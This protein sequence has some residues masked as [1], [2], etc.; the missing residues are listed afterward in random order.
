MT[1]PVWRDVSVVLLAVEAFVLAL[2]PL[3]V[4]YVANKGF[5]RLRSSLRSLFPRV[6]DQARRVERITTKVS[7]WIVSPIIGAYGLLA[8]VRA[9]VLTIV[10]LPRGGV[11]R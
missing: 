3:A 9:V 6:L 4:L 7:G 1:L 8:H 10:G 2:V 5:L 11:R